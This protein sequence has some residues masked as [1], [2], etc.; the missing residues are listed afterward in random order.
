MR[1]WPWLEPRACAGVCRSTPSTRSPRAASRY[2]AALPIPPRPAKITSYT[3]TSLLGVQLHP[4]AVPRCSRQSTVRRDQ[5]RV[6]RLGERHVSRVV[7]GQVIPQVPNACGYRSSAA[8][9]SLRRARRARASE[10]APRRAW[11]RSTFS[12]STSK[13][14]GTCSVSSGCAILSRRRPAAGPKFK[15]TA[16]AAEVSRT[17]RGATPSPGGLRRPASCGR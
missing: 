9:E 8:P 5:R 12:T 16:T 17:I 10:R 4:G 15:S 2:A 14:C 7:R 3:R 1:D 11:R 13:R 6:E